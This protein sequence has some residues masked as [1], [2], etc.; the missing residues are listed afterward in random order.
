VTQQSLLP[1]PRK[2]Q[3]RAHARKS[4]PWTS[5]AA[6]AEQKAVRLNQ[7]QQRVQGCL[8]AGPCTLEDLVTRYRDLYPDDNCTDSSIRSRCKE[9]EPKGITKVVGIGKSSRGKPAQIWGLA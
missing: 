2:P 8:I 6:A 5:H 4:H 9:L 3:E 7:I 1:E